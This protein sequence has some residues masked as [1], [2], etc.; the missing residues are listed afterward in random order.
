[1]HIFTCESSI[2]FASRMVEF[3]GLVFQYSQTD[4]NWV[5]LTIMMGKTLCPLYLINNLILKGIIFHLCFG[6]G[7]RQVKKH[8]RKPDA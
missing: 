4:W 8:C 6:L 5:N 2:F 7:S 1:M 3:A